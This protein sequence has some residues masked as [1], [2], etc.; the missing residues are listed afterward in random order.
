[1]VLPYIIMCTF[2]KQISRISSESILRGMKKEV[3]LQYYGQSISKDFS[4]S[5]GWQEDTLCAR[6]RVGR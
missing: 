1:M 3:S 4:Q 6:I 5:Y 2:C